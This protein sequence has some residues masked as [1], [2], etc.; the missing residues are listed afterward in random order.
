[1]AL[2]PLALLVSA[3]LLFGEPM[4]ERRPRMTL[5]TTRISRALRPRHARLRRGTG[6]M[7][8]PVTAPECRPRRE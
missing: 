5:T 6:R 3:A 1:M 2:Y 4:V 8:I 7:G